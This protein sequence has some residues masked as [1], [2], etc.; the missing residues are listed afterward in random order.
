M[1]AAAQTLGGKRPTDCSGRLAASC[2]TPYGSKMTN[3][4]VL[5]PLPAANAAA[6]PLVH[7]PLVLELVKGVPTVLVTLLIGVIAT[8][9]AWRQC[10]VAKEQRRIAHAKLNLDL[11]QRRYE[12]FELTWAMLSSMNKLRDDQETVEAEFSNARPRALSLW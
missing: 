6:I 4:A 5:S 1:H 8:Y 9:I 7:D 10:K 3:L 11:F 12:I 2:D